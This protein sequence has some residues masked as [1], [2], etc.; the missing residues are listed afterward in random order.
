MT[1]CDVAKFVVLTS[2]PVDTLVSN[3]GASMTYFVGSFV[4]NVRVAELRV[5][6]T[7]KVSRVRG[8]VGVHHSVVRGGQRIVEVLPYESEAEMV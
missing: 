6:V 4:V 2:V 8:I 1:V 7:V 3:A 5:G